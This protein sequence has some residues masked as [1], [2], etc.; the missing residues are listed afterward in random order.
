MNA[1]L[2]W[3]TAATKTSLADEAETAPDLEPDPVLH[4][5]G[6]SCRCHASNARGLPRTGRAVCHTCG[7]G[8]RHA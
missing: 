4:L 2:R 5:R 3:P 6:R 8:N 7:H 1:L